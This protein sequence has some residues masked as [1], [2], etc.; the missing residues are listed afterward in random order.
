MSLT[1]ADFQFEES[2]PEAELLE[3]YVNLMQT[4]MDA[5]PSVTVD[6]FM[7]DF[8]PENHK[9]LVEKAQQGTVVLFDIPRIDPIIDDDNRVSDIR[10]SRDEITL[11]WYICAYSERD[12]K[13][14]ERMLQ[15]FKVMNRVK[16]VMASQ[17]V[18][19]TSGPG[20]ISSPDN[21]AFPRPRE[22]EKLNNVYK[23]TIYEVMYTLKISQDMSL[24]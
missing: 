21:A 23:M 4:D 12:D 17:A 3:F 5:Y 24:V 11:G 2:S 19:Y 1:L 16:K 18:A 20:T 9:W 6:V 22:I 14:L 8:S 15:V 13:G 7:E 10:L